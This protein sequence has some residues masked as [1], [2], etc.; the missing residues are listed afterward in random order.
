[1]RRRRSGHEPTPSRTSGTI[2]SFLPHTRSAS[3]ADVMAK[4]VL[5]LLHG[6]K[7]TAPSTASF[8]KTEYNE[9]AIFIA[10]QI[11]TSRSP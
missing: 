9:D 10:D 6:V 11:L 4:K 1:M 2:A 8:Y 5:N 3:L 7:G